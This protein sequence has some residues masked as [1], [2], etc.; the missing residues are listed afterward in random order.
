MKR[1]CLP[2]LTC[3]ALAAGPQGSAHAEQDAEI[4]TWQVDVLLFERPASQDRWPPRPIPPPDYSQ[5]RR[6]QAWQDPLEQLLPPLRDG[7]ALPPAH[8]QA[9]P[10]H[11]QGL[12]A[13]AS[14]LQRS[15][16]Y[17]VLAHYSWTQPALPRQAHQPVRLLPPEEDTKT[18]RE[19]EALLTLDF[20]P[21]G[22]TMEKK[23]PVID[24]QAS[25]YQGS[26][27][28][29][30]LDLYY[31]R[32]ALHQPLRTEPACWR[33]QQD[34]RVRPEKLYYYDHRHFGALARIRKLEPAATTETGSQP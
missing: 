10:P 14:R 23:A 26:Y 29:L 24:G 20:P 12:L 28:H 22:T 3:L 31:C 18:P 11:Q 8:W 32:D 17:R 2:L 27:L 5:A 16:R 7:H 30:K 15:G 19:S 25:L 33:L 4:P 1:T 21:A 34:Y 6:L 13:E 9:L